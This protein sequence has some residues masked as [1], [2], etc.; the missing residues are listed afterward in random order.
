MA[1]KVHLP[2]AWPRA[3]HRP[4]HGSYSKASAARSQERCAQAIVHRPCCRVADS[5]LQRCADVSGHLAMS[6][7]VCLP[8]SRES[9][10]CGHAVSS[11]TAYMCS[12]LNWCCNLSLEPGDSAN[13]THSTHFYT[14]NTYH[15]TT[16]R[17]LCQ[18]PCESARAAGCP[19]CH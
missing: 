4:S 19:H 13:A 12:L 6:H 2:R 3:R 8:F 1:A 16:I 11:V 17:A 10:Q 7:L 5:I 9:A 18:L 14:A 15:R